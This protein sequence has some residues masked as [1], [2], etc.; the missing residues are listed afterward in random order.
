VDAAEVDADDKK[1][2]QEAGWMSGDHTP[3]TQKLEPE[4]CVFSLS[5]DSRTLS[6]HGRIVDAVTITDNEQRQHRFS[7]DNF[8][9]HDGCKT[10]PPVVGQQHQQQQLPQ[11][12]QL[13][14]N[15]DG[16]PHRISG[17]SQVPVQTSSQHNSDCSGPPPVHTT[18]HVMG[19]GH[20][21]K[22]VST[23]TLLPPRTKRRNA[24]TGTQ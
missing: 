7:N 3:P 9:K 6:G 5:S 24:G 8:D 17:A 1:L 15:R 14:A 18:S 16:S 12:L 19:S 11:Q 23:D 13:P 10:I 20:P 4:E 2:Q 21:V 22:R